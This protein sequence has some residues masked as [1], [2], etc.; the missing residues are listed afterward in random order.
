MLIQVG[1]RF[2]NFSSFVTILENKPMPVIE[3]W[4]FQ[5]FNKIRM[6]K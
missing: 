5:G 6:I 2:F 3:I 4:W 1:K